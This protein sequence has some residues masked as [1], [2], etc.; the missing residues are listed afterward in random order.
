MVQF[1]TDYGLFLLKTITVV[2]AILIIIGAAV[3]ASAK[4]RRH[5][6]DGTIKVKALHE[7]Y[8]RVREDME[9][10]IFSK[11]DL[12]KIHKQRKETHKSEKKKPENRP[13]V[14]VIDFEGDLKVSHGDEL[15][16]KITAVLSIATEAD[17]VVVR[18]E[19][20]GGMVHAYGLAASQLHRIRK[21]NIALTI[22]VDKVAASGGYLMA[23]L[24]TKILAA[25][26]AVIGSIGVVAQ[27]PNFHRLLKKNDVDVEVLTAGEFKR[28]LTMFGENTE[29]GRAK[30]LEDLEDT[31]TL[32]KNFVNEHRPQLDMDQ[33]ATGEHWY[34]T[35]AQSLQLIDEIMTSDEYLLS[36]A[37]SADIYEIGYE[38]KKPFMERLPLLLQRVIDDGLT[39]FFH[40]RRSTPFE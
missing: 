21:K 34:G 15:A 7:E 13:R 32:F 19:S 20:P 35:R 3:A 27:I 2:V 39:Q 33:V 26:F 22:A 5:D 1:I 28:T 29:A 37:E 10:S 14:Y 11:D 38:V 17:E 16:H 23:V 12:K 36:K 40:R 4:G 8:T 18:L 25:P 24:G 6:D 31:H 9:D 30:F